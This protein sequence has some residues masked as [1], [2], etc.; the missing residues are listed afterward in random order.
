VDDLVMRG[1]NL[2]NFC[3]DVLSHL[4]DLL[5]VKVS[6]DLKL[7]DSAAA[8]AAALQQQASLFSESDLVRFFHSLAETESSLKDAAN[9]R[10]QLEVGL[11]KLM[12]LRRLAPLGELFE[13]M[14]ALEDTLRTGKPPA[15]GKTP[16]AALASGSSRTGGARTATA[17]GSASGT[18]ASSSSE[19]QTTDE[20]PI[21]AVSIAPESVIEKI[22]AALEQ[23]KRRL[24]VAALDGA[25]RAELDG[26]E[27][28]VEFAPEAKHYRD[29][30]AK[31]ESAKI[32]R[33][34]CTEVCGRKIGIRFAIKDGSDD[35]RKAPSSEEEERRAKQRAHQGVAQ[36]PTV[37]QVLRAFGGEIVDIKFE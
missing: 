28:L 22:K 21:A 9:P 1:H 14:S 8:R 29:A 24:L 11:V 35:D 3:R 15:E 13:R 10:Y 34:V 2:R 4:R 27:L 16:Q 36:N 25:R 26:D 23:K 32:L 37:Q 6:G 31:A 33:E 19:P 7:L 20:P 30:L 17:A 5:V 18:G 12:E